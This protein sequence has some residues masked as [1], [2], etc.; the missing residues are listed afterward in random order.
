[1]K[2]SM[3]AVLVLVGVVFAGQGAV[4][5]DVLALFDDFD[6]GVLGPEWY[7]TYSGSLGWEADEVGT[8]LI[9]TDILP[10]AVGTSQAFYSRVYLSRQFVPLSDFAAHFDISWDS[11]G[12]VAAHQFLLLKFRSADGE[13]IAQGGYAD[14]WVTWSG[15]KNARAGENGYSSGNNTMPLAGATAVEITRTNGQVDVWFDGVHAVSGTSTALLARA[16]IIFQLYSYDGPSGKS[17]FG[18][19][20]VDLV[21][22]EGVADGPIPPTCDEL[23]AACV[24]ELN[25]ANA[26]IAALSNDL[27]VANQAVAALQADL[28]AANATISGLSNDL[29][30]ANQTIAGLQ[31]DLATANQTIT[32]L[33]GD[34]ATAN[35]TISG[36]QSDLAAANATIAGLQNDLAAANA[37]IT[38]LQ[39]ENATLKNTIQ[40]QADQNQHLWGIIVWLAGIIWG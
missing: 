12:T 5:E 34:L 15:S 14:S 6:D 11:V 36:L 29:A 16:D 3:I 8:E 40:R 39:T 9:V 2:R 1:M 7:I 4:G 20:S 35:Q 33:Q 23:L 22:I 19:E 26:A 31:T 25:A 10:E 28:A 18:T 38:Q 21:S 17:L 13:R 30:V 37:T 24:A 27:V 32:G